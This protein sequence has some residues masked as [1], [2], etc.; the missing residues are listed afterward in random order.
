MAGNGPG[1][2]QASCAVAAS[3]GHVGKEWLKWGH[4]F[5]AAHLAPTARSGEGNNLL[6]TLSP[7][8]CPPATSPPPAPSPAN[9]LPGWGS[10]E[11]PPNCS[12]NSDRGRWRVHC[13][14]SSK[15]INI[16]VSRVKSR[17]LRTRGGCDAVSVRARRGQTLLLARRYGSLGAAGLLALR[18][19][20]Q[21]TSCGFD[22]LLF[23]FPNC[24][25]FVG[26]W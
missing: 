2:Q 25:F 9:Q 17:E 22:I 14:R 16:R 7:S 15:Y 13:K 11:G 8:R 23:F 6:A 24:H 21:E 18:K 12:A 5:S 3:S 19:R 10:D 4:L 20:Q 1:L 26:S